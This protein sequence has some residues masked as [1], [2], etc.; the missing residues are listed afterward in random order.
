MVYKWHSLFKQGRE[1]LEDDPRPGR[2]IEDARGHTNLG[3][4]LHLNG[5]YREAADSYKEALRLQ[6]NDVTTLTN[7]H[8]L[9]SVMT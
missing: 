6:P 5:K 8:K 7:L 2:S 4:I 1:S 9:H 3:A